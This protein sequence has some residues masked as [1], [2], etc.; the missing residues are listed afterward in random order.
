MDKKGEGEKTT[1]KEQWDAKESSVM[2]VQGKEGDK[3]HGGVTR[4]REK[5]EPNGKGAHGNISHVQ[6]LLLFFLSSFSSM[7]MDGELRD[8]T[9]CSNTQPSFT[10]FFFFFFSPSDAL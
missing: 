8:E 3:K 10:P 5:K 9:T 7:L 4:G 6:G 1:K 2:R